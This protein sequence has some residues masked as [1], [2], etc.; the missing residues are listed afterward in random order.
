VKRFNLSFVSFPLAVAIGFSV[1]SI[2][3][4]TIILI[5][6]ETLRNGARAGLATMA[7]PI[8]IDATIMIPLGLS[9]QTFLSKTGEVVLEFVGASFLLWLAIK[10]LRS[11]TAGSGAGIDREGA[12]TNA[13]VLPSFLKGV[14]IHLTSP[15]P[16]LYWATVGGSFIR[17]GMEVDGLWGAALFP[18]G[19][20]LGATGFTVTVIF[21]LARGRRFLP[22]SIATSLP[23][24]CSI[25]LVAG[26]LYLALCAWRL[27][28]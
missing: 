8:L 1:A 18:L 15:Y 21:A 5:S 7:A 22:P 16:Y 25:L 23:R 28:C 17:Q 2:P 20:W 24:L 9:L 3:G 14:L 27:W 19:F 13:K 10:S 4:P 6:A 11:A 26:A 12:A